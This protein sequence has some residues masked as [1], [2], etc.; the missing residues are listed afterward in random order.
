MRSSSSA[1]HSVGIH[2]S[3]RRR[4]IRHR[5]VEKSH[6]PARAPDIGEAKW[7]SR[8]NMIRTGVYWTA[9][10]A[11]AFGDERVTWNP[12]AWKMRATGQ[13]WRGGKVVCVRFA[14]PDDSGPG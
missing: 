12:R 4:S 1:V 9:T 13:R 11:D 2:V 10:K 14:N 7:I 6:P 8:S 5:L 3:G